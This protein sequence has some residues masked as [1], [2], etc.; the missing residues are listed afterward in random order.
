MATAAFPAVIFPTVFCLTRR[1][2][3]VDEA[4]ARL[5][6]EAGLHAHGVEQIERRSHATKWSPAGAGEGRRL[7]SKARLEKITK[8]LADLK[9]KSGF[10][11]CQMEK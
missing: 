8:D 10:H 3:L 7:D 11:D 5:K 1:W 6:I 9:E 2:T 4:A